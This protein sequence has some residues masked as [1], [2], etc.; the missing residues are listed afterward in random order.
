VGNLEPVNT[1]GDSDEAEQQE[2]HKVT[3]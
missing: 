2:A 3:S 1:L